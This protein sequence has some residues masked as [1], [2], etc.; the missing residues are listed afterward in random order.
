M[1]GALDRIAILDNYCWPDPVLSEKTPDGE[2][3]M[4]QFRDHE[5]L[6][7]LT[8]LYK[9]PAISGKDSCKNDSTRG[10]VKISI[11]PTLL[12]SSVGQIKDV[13]NAVTMHFKTE[14]DLIYVIG[15]TKDE[16]EHLLIIDG[17][18]RKMVILNLLVE[19]FQKLMVNMLY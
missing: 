17:L 18:Q 7:D 10:G 2:Y 4:A 3:K 8:T 9:T 16:L 11:P 5:A 12:I 6:Y 13:R 14:G 15:R 1:G 19:R